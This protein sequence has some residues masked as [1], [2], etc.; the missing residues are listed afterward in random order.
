MRC[1]SPCPLYPNSDCESRPPQ[2]VMSAVPP[3]AGMC[4]AK[5]DVLFGPKADIRADETANRLCFVE[6]IPPR[7]GGPLRNGPIALRT[8]ERHAFHQTAQLGRIDHTTRSIALM[9]RRP[10]SQVNRKKPAALTSPSEER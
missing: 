3:I 1:N 10:G 2:T 4:G 8:I 7:S 9:P 6:P 5:A